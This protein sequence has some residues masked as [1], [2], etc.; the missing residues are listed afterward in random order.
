MR[1]LLYITSYI[2]IT[3]C[4]ANK[5][6]T[7]I[8]SGT[9]VD[10]SEKYANTI[11]AKDLGKHLFIFGSDEFEG[12]RTGESGQKKAVEYLKDF[13]V[14][15]GIKSPISEGDYFQEISSEYLTKNSRE[16]KLKA[17]ENVIAFIKGTEKPD[18]VVVISAHLDH[19]GVKNEKVFN[20]ADDNGSGTSAILE[21]AEAFKKSVDE[22]KG[23]KRSVLFFHVTG[24]EEG[25]LGSKYYAENPIFSLANTVSNLNIDMIG[26]VDKYH[27]ENPNYIYLIGSDKLSSE[28]HHI[29]ET[30]N[31][32]YTKI[33]LDYKY[34]DKKDPNQFYY[35]SDHYNFAKHNIPVIFYFNGIHDD[36]HKSTDTADKIN[37]EMLEKRVR[38][39]FHT[40]WELTNRK[41][42]IKIDKEY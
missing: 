39:I 29:S 16:K 38:L 42:R 6:A 2:A 11:T 24:E 5:G 26:R 15:K 36:Y 41:E 13:Y 14:K 20:G 32:K 7:G 28:L 8:K 10:S 37:Y 33:D 21:I 40:A 25:L 19:L 34:N 9:L 31:K 4:I 18:E 30:I 22:G 23:P 1:K 27:T 35:R 3:G 17:S 12:R